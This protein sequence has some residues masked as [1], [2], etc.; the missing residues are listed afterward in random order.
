M[1]VVF[2][3]GGR[4][5]CLALMLTQCFFL[6]SYPAIYSSNLKWYLTSFSYAPS[7]FVWLFLVKFKKAKLHSIFW[8]WGMYVL[9]LVV[10]TAIVFTIAGDSLDKDRFLGPNLLKKVLC[11]TPL[12]LLFLLKTAEDI[13]NHMELVVLPNGF[14][15]L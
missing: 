5:F 15:S 9:G 4:I 11:I 8:I 13:E 6:A 12:L 3:W 10:S 1:D 2:L 14:G 7:V